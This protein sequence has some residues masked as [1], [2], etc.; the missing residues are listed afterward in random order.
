MKKI[1][2]IGFAALLLL[3]FCSCMTAR[4]AVKKVLEDPASKEKVGRE[5]E[6]ENPCANDS[7]QVFI[8]GDTLL[9]TD[10]I[11]NTITETVE[12][13][14]KSRVNT[15]YKTITN[16]RT[17]HDSIRV[18]VVDIRRAR[19]AE[20]SANFYRGVIIQKEGQISASEKDYKS[21]RS[22]K[23]KWQWFSIILLIIIAGFFTR[24]LW[25]PAVAKI[26]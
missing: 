12:V 6:K 21:M 5:W 19:I 14:G 10:T 7:V 15:V 9:T 1:L 4:K 13:P 24:K 16:T 2:F 17:I 26:V 8:A 22:S 23:R 3:H 25:M 18:T 11:T 20:D